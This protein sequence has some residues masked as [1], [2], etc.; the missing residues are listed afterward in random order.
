VLEAVDRRVVGL[1]LEQRALLIERCV[2]G[3][4]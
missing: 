2:Q 3:S 1:E 4:S